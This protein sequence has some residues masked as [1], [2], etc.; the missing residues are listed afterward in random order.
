M[1]KRWDSQLARRMVLALP[2][3][4][5]REQQ[6]ALVRQYC[7]EQFVDKGMCCDLCIH[8]KEDG[9]PH[10]HIMLTLRGIDEKGKWLPK[11]RKVYD[12]DEDGQRI[13]LPSGN[14]KS[15]KEDVVDWN[16]HRYGEVWRHEWEVLQNQ[17][18]EAAG[19]T[20]RVDMRSYERQGIDQLPTVHMGA[21]VTQ[22]E[23]KGIQTDIGD[24]N[25]RIQA[26]NKVL[27]S[28]R[29][30]LRNLL[31][32]IEDLK[33]QREAFKAA[34]Q[35][36]N[37]NE[38]F[39]LLNAYRNKRMAER[40]GWSGVAQLR[41]MTKDF[42][43]IEPAIKYLAEHDIRTVDSLTAHLTQ[44]QEQTAALQTRLRGNRSQ[45]N[46]C[47]AAVKHCKNLEAYRAVHDKYSKMRFK[48]LKDHYAAEH[49]TELE[50]YQTAVRFFRAN[51]SYKD[52]SPSEILQMQRSLKKEE[53]TL[54]GRF[55]TIYQE[56]AQLKNVKFWIAQVK[57]YN[58]GYETV[59][60]LTSIR[61][62]LKEKSKEKQERTQAPNRSKKREESL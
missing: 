23:R 45:Q 19:R 38:L 35:E 54:E 14:W 15:H 18:L 57:N 25:R 53:T 52:K 61:G 40:S 16:D 11:S 26:V 48:L 6:I 4:L 39:D 62:R 37:S 58:A 42:Y 7:K 10:A 21:A 31:N 1:E 50:A 36:A 46:K 22:M 17:Y 51:P 34:W 24:L 32:W 9:N 56:L 43:R 59:P 60:E 3:E 33:A 30:T 49:R 27:R 13:R 47:A 20:E 28:I 5:S 2:R 8:D 44:I 29:T 55:D 41:G 12:L